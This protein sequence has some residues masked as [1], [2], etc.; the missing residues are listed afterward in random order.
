MKNLFDFADDW[1]KEIKI[2]LDKINKLEEYE[3][4]QKDKLEFEETRTTFLKQFIKWQDSLY[5]EMKKRVEN[6]TQDVNSDDYKEFIGQYNEFKQLQDLTTMV[7]ALKENRDLSEEIM[8][9]F[10]K[11]EE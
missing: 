5:Q 6:G 11:E 2:D 1:R 7:E 10:L 3:E 4:F 9:E 8:A